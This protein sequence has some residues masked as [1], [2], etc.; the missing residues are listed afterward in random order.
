M[1]IQEFESN[2]YHSLYDF[3]YDK[4]FEMLPDKKQFRKTI[5]TGF[6]NVIFSITTYDSEIWLEVNLGVR[7]DKVEKIAQQFLDIQQELWE[8]SNTVI[9]SVGKLTSNKYFRYK[10]QNEEDEALVIQQITEFMVDVGSIFLDSVSTLISLDRAF[11]YKP[12]KPC[13]YLYNQTHRCFKGTVVSWL[14]KSE[15]YERLTELYEEYLIKSNQP[16]SVLG[17]YKK[18]KAHLEKY[19]PHTGIN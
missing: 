3:F 12:L 2:L 8:E 15:K 10:V 18:L 4:N 5:E 13:K 7:N 16:P 11:N 14:L 19:Y 9:I 17:S 1:T 6:Q